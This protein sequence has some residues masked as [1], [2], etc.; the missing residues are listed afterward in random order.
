MSRRVDDGSDL[1]QKSR[2]RAAKKV[3]LVLNDDER[4]EL[5]RDVK[6]KMRDGVSG[7]TRSQYTPVQV[8]FVAF[9]YQNYREA[10]P[11]VVNTDFF[12]VE[13]AVDDD[14]E[15]NSDYLRDRISAQ[16]DGGD[17]VDCPL[18]LESVTC[19][20]VGQYLLYR[21]KHRRR[22]GNENE[23]ISD[24]TINGWAS[25]IKN[26]FSMFN[27]I[28][29]A[30]YDAGVAKVKKGYRKETVEDRDSNGDGK[31]AMPFDLLRWL[32]K[33]ML[34]GVDQVNVSH[35]DV[36]FSHAYMLLQWNLM[37]RSSNTKMIS[38]SHL[39][40]VDDCLTV[41]FRKQK[42]DQDGSRS[43]H[44]RHVYANPISPEVCPILAIALWLLCFPPA[45]GQADLFEG[46]SQDSRF[47]EVFRKVLNS[48]AVR[49]ELEKRGFTAASFGSHSLRKG[50]SSFVS[51]GTTDAPPQISIILRG[52]WTLTQIEK[53]YFR[54]EKAGDQYVGRV[55]SGLSIHS[56]DF[57]LLPPL[58]Y[59]RTPDEVELVKNLVETCFPRMPVSMGGVSR[60]L[61]ASVIYHSEWLR[62]E[63]GRNHPI[64]NTAIFS[65]FDMNQ[66]KPLVKCTLPGPDTIVS[67]GVPAHVSTK[68]AI[69]A[70]Q[71][72]QEVLHKGFQDFRESFSKDLHAGL[73]QYAHSQ[74]HLTVDSFSQMLNLKFDAFMEATKRHQEPASVPVMSHASPE[75]QR[76]LFYW[77][78]MYHLLPEDFEIPK[79]TTEQMFMLWCCGNLERKYP[80][81]RVVSPKEFSARKTRKRFS[82]LRVFMECL[83]GAAKA[84]GDCSWPKDAQGKWLSQLD[85]K[86]AAGVF[87]SIKDEFDLSEK[88]SKGRKRRLHQLV[89][90]THLKEARKAKKIS[91]VGGGGKRGKSK[92][93]N[94]DSLQDIA[95][96]AEDGSGEERSDSESE[97]PPP[98]PPKK[99]QK[100][101]Q[102]RL[103]AKKKVV[104]RTSDA[105]IEQESEKR[106]EV[107]SDNDP[108]MIRAIAQSKQHTRGRHG[109]IPG[110]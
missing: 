25:A 71:N 93:K 60:L 39:G 31:D 37:C 29:P 107:D 26:L 102:S 95:T 41:Y 91:A 54:F 97:P 15:L 8:D 75:K 42:N 72:Q 86:C 83:E 46:T 51:A 65:L 5:E 34:K 84:K 49:T 20:I 50:A 80:P 22:K 89:W 110:G 78:G 62:T 9:C 52:G 47:N 106:A 35:A 48:D 104:V 69:R 7:N 57:S 85:S 30:E 92:P 82:D 32:S 4:E 96:D 58:F 33:L 87:N 61:L 14:G 100:L 90:T 44:P 103:S 99:V 21:A 88:T 12:A 108:D 18:L 19:D 36:L 38:F 68:L 17:D 98:P 101:K 73:N 70:L 3:N 6:K 1:P 109:K 43:K 11:A 105:A 53:T 76:E 10:A 94:A 74:G 23:P 77:G 2:K 66:L 24:S 67:T 45:E 55:V 16:L 59:E 64:F 79:G 13:G 40:A 28:V 56:T 81:L 63:L 27:V